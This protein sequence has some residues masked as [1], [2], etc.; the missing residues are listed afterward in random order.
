VLV[1]SIETLLLL[2]QC[3]D[4]F[5]EKCFIVGFGLINRINIGRPFVEIDL[6][7]FAD[8][9]ILTLDFHGAAFSA[10][11]QADLYHQDQM[12]VSS[13]PATIRV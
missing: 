8:A 2:A 13:Q 10:Q 7:A 12:P 3:V 6:V 11:G 1:R 5:G 4:L 9:K